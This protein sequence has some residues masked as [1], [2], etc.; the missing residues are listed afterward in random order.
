MDHMENEMDRCDWITTS[1]DLLKD[2]DFLVNVNDFLDD[3]VDIS[4]TELDDIL[5]GQQFLWDD[6]DELEVCMPSTPFYEICGTDPKSEGKVCK[7]VIPICEIC[8][9]APK[10][11][12]KV[13]EAERDTT[14]TDFEKKLYKI[15]RILCQRQN[16][17]C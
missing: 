9:T 1:H 10:A 6:Q 16:S 17:H 7:P 12:P 4:E 8:E 5:E 15:L 11:K 13:R 3:E 2:D 14:L